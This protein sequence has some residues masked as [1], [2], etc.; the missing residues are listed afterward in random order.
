MSERH[1]D[2]WFVE[3]VL[4]HE[5]ALVGFLRVHWREASEIHDLRQEI[6]ARV[7]EAAMRE[8]PKAV[9][10]FL[11]TTARNLIIDKARRGKVVCMDTVADFDGLSVYTDEP[12]A[13]A[14]FSSRQELKALAAALDTLPEKC[15][16]IV[17]MRK[18][19]GRPQ[20]EVAR[21][22]GVAESTVEKQVMKG[23][24]RLADVLY[25]KG[26]PFDGER[27]GRAKRAKRGES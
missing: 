1:I 9:K 27:A 12:D 16:E 24:K 19:E 18:I 2:D 4:V 5:A 20:R 10:T 3:E 14:V 21:T 7:Y 6:Y 8:R 13:E 23:V 11:F 26:A 15:R 25:G 22:L 17:V